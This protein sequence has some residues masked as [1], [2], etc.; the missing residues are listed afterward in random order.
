MLE[1]TNDEGMKVRSELSDASHKHSGTSAAA[2][3]GWFLCGILSRFLIATSSLHTTLCPAKVNPS[4]VY[5][6]NK[7][8][9]FIPV[10]TN[11]QA[12]WVPQQEC[13]GR[14]VTEGAAIQPYGQGPGPF[15]LFALL[16]PSLC[17]SGSSGGG[18][19]G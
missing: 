16:F 10:P 7:L 8:V 2:F 13:G 17:R 11:T 18:R 9:L 3:A 19:G 15:C 4:S 6:L 14:R 1:L 5:L 12:C